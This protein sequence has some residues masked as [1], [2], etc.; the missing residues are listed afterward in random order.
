MTTFF[1]FIHTN[2]L[3]HIIL[4]INIIRSYKKSASLHPHRPKI[5]FDSP[6]AHV[7]V[8]AKAAELVLTKGA[9]EIQAFTIAFTENLI[10]IIFS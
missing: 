2:L 7:E 6:S 3:K 10:S 5:D 1:C 8:V 4:I 9:K